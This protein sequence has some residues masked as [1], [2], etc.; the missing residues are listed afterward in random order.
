[1]IYFMSCNSAVGVM[2]K[3]AVDLKSQ[4][5]EATALK[6]QSPLTIRCDFAVQSLCRNVHFRFRPIVK[7]CC[8][9]HRCEELLLVSERTAF[10]SASP[11][12]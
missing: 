1:M 11:R 5:E 6:R 12:L 3:I 10:S 9:D 4:F 2:L 8:N 7:M